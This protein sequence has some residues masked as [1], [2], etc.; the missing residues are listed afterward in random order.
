MAISEE[1]GPFRQRRNSYSNWMQENLPEDWAV[2][3]P[4]MNDKRTEFEFNPI[5]PPRGGASGRARA[6]L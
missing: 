2:E 5:S 1:I 4:G 6:H 3:E